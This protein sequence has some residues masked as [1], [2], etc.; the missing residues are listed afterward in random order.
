VDIR[1]VQVSGGV[2]LAAASL[3][4]GAPGY[5]SFTL[6]GGAPASLP[7]APAY[8]ATLLAGTYDIA[9]SGNADPLCAG[10]LPCN[11]GTI[12][13]GVA[14]TASGALDLDVRAAKVTGTVTLQGAP[15]AISG[16]GMLAFT[17]VPAAD[18]SIAAIPLA[19]AFTVWLA[20]GTYNAS[21]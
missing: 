9:Y 14:L 18:G 19:P 4:E 11:A 16:S 15:L 10:P 6:A 1:A 7:I 12:R 2:T 8:S 21:Y 3:P 5:L 17:P 20:P 13:K